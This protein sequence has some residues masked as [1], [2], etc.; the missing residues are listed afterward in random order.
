MNITILS[1][2]SSFAVTAPNVT[3]IVNVTNFS[4]VDRQ[5]EASVAGEGHVHFYM[6]V[7][8][9][10]TTAGEPAIPNNTSAAWAHV[11]GTNYTFTNVTAGEHTFAVQLVNNDHTPVIPI[12][13]QSV[14][15]QVGEAGNTSANATGSPVTGA[16]GMVVLALSGSTR[17]TP[18]WR[19]SLPRRPR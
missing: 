15:V 9:I 7:S 13:M 8:P 19:R 2:N 6:D 11:S 14:T 16:I 17:T 4:V 5:G 1:P 3:V 12:V 18:A 10:P